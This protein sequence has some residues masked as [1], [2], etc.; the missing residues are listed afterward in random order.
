MKAIS[1][2]FEF[3]AANNLK[4]EDIIKFYIEDHNYTRF[5]RSTKNIFIVGERGAGKT[6]T[7][8]YNSFSIQY[9]ISQGNKAIANFDKIGIHV[10][11][12]TPLFHKKEY[13]L[14]KEE[15]KKYIICEHYLVLSI[16]FNIAKT[17]SE[18]P[19]IKDGLSKIDNYNIQNLQYI[20][21]TSH[22][23]RSEYFFNDIRTFVNKE[24]RETQI[25]INTYGNDSFYETSYSFSS[26]LLPFF[27]LLKSIPC[28][29]DSHFLLM[30]DDA[31]DMNEYQIRT[32]NSW[33]AYRDHSIFSFKIAIA[34]IAELDR[35]TSS[36][37]SILEGHDYLT[38]EMGKD[39]YNKDSDFYKF[40]K[41][42]IETRL[43]RIGINIPAE[44]FFPPNND[45][46]KDI[47]VARSKARI[48]AETKYS[49]PK[50]I[51]EY[52]KKYHRAIYFRDRSPKANTPP[53]A[54]FETLVDISTGII[55]NL[56]DPCYWMFDNIVSEDN[57]D[58][59]KLTEIS[60]AIQNSII[61]QRSASLWTIL[62]EG[63]DKIIPNCS[64]KEGEQIYTMFDRLMI[65]FKKRLLADISEPRA[66]VFTLTGEKKFPQEYE[67]IKKLLDISRKAQMLYTRISSGKQ[68]GSKTI[69]YVPNRMLLPDR[70]LDIKG[71][72]SQVPIPVKDLY[73]TIT[74]DQDLPF[75]LENRNNDS[76]SH[77][78]TLNLH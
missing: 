29:K 36:G 8:L 38:I 27:D 21:G 47:E 30:I 52:I 68:L 59:S 71:Q 54:G 61:Q 48:L 50:K 23:F 57:F 43:S 12:N 56:L 25:K 4:D 66:I 19:E 64:N 42:I 28:L 67:H 39:L 2:P 70:G 63:L 11:C 73:Q 53:Y 74:L 6:M 76:S 44:T 37:G 65:L 55:R 18:I 35:Q 33:I 45:F 17:L 7:L 1:N 75:F 41:D 34:R 32:L 5:I 58:I 9:K 15:H 78:L 49:E 13:L 46:L 72:Y 69:Y 40:A 24:I 62:R 14:L 31:H 16:L 51:T 20:W 10:P 26:L 22:D 60:P 77:Q 3:E